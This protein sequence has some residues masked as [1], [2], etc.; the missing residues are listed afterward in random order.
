[1]Y[2]AHGAGLLGGGFR[3]GGRDGTRWCV[4]EAQSAAVG[5]GAG[6]RVVVEPGE[7]GEGMPAAFSSPAISFRLCVGVFCVF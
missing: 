1:M 7:K 5:V 2:V 6:V 3:G 4:G